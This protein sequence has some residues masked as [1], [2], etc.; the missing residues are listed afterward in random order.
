MKNL[1]AQISNSEKFNPT[2]NLI[3]LCLALI[4]LADEPT[5]DMDSV[6]GLEIMALI[7][8]LNQIHNKTIICVTHDEEMLKPGMRLIHMDDGRIISDTLLMKLSR[9]VCLC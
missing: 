5:G 8:E 2:S 9:G 4:I 3:A 1:V 7:S 6:I